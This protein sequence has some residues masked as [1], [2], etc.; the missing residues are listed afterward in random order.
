MNIKCCSNQAS[1]HRIFECQWA[2][3]EEKRR[4]NNKTIATRDGKRIWF[5]VYPNVIII[6][7]CDVNM[8]VCVY[9]SSLFV[10]FF[11]LVFHSFRIFSHTDEWRS[12]WNRS[13]WYS[14]VM[15]RTKTRNTFCQYK[16]KIY[17]WKWRSSGWS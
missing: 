3:S 8:C 4:G 2:K 12:N 16:N 6:Y 1:N 14:P 9:A 17:I 11:F 13:T 5:P 10:C 7:S 15:A